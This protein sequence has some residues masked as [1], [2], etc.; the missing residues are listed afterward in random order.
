MESY[1]AKKGRER[2][3]SGNLTLWVKSKFLNLTRRNLPTV[4]NGHERKVDYDNFDLLEAIMFRQSKTS[5]NNRL[6][7]ESTASNSRKNTR[8]KFFSLLKY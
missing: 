4:V 8:Y 7:E 6:N 3:F 1:S 2:C 5:K